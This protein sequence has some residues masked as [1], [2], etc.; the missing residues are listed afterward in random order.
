MTAWIFPGQG[1]QKR[2]MAS[3]IEACSELFEEAR[4][5]LQVNLEPLCTTDSD[6][7]WAPDTLQPAL[8]A[9]EVGLVRK[10]DDEGAQPSVVAGH[11]LG[12]FPALVAAGALNAA[13]GLKLVAARGKAMAAAGRRNPGGMAAVIGLDPDTISEIC[14]EI[15]GVWISN[16]NS[17]KQTVISGE[18]R[19]L[20]Q[21][22]E[23]CRKAGAAKVIRL[24]VPLAAHCPLMQ[25]AAY[26][27]AEALE[28]VSL[29]APRVPVYCGADGRA[30][31][32]PSEIGRLLT[33]AIT[34]PVLFTDTI[35]AITSDGEESF[36][37]VG[38]GKVLRGLARQIKSGLTL[39]GVADDAA[40]AEFAQSEASAS[41]GNPTNKQSRR[42][43]IHT[44]EPAMGVSR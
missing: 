36:V 29:H 28:Q 23:A 15:D 14:R 21:A 31:D 39:T 20:V 8:Y 4:R 42:T 35:R 24:Q 33:K 13:D 10:L 27:F 25:P 44:T 37:E 16:L 5:T 18:D 3:A 9:T 22:A 6:P 19:S 40:A 38:P 30:H 26:E 43:T 2:G 12:E 7:T 34:A 41:G 17:P 1:S 32:N 11:S